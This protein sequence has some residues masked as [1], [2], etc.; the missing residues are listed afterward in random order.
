MQRSSNPELFEGAKVKRLHLSAVRPRMQTLK[1]KTNSQFKIACTQPLTLH[2][3]PYC[4]LPIANCL[5]FISHRPSLTC[6]PFYPAILSRRSLG[7][8]GSFSV[9]GNFL[10]RYSLLTSIAFATEVGDGC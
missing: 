5:V 7:E 10:T 9:V 1:P 6:S 4:L 8:G 2:L 3:S